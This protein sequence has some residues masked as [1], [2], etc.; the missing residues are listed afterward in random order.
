MQAGCSEEVLLVGV[1][2]VASVVLL[3]KERLLLL[4]LLLLL[5]MSLTAVLPAPPAQGVGCVKKAASAV[6]PGGILQ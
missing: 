6:V 2:E 5:L 1:A 3:A 4:L